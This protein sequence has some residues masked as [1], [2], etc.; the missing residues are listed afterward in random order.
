MK[1]NELRIGNWINDNEHFQGWFQVQ[2]IGYEQIESPDYVLT[3]DEVSGIPLTE[4]W[5]KKIDWNG[6]IYL[7]FNSYFSMDTSGH[8]YYRSDYT[9]INVSYVHEL[10]NLYFALTGTELELK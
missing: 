7:H 10:Q 1:N 4:E 2:K 6:Y 5:L 8:I 3:L 9:G